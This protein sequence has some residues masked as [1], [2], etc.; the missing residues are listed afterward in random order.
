MA[1]VV[2]VYEIP[3]GL[4]GGLSVQD[5]SGGNY[6]RVLQVEF[7]GIN[8]FVWAALEAVGDSESVPVYGEPHPEDL[9]SWCY[10]KR[11]E[12]VPDDPTTW[13]VTCRYARSPVDPN[14]PN[15]PQPPSQNGGGEPPAPIPSQK[16]TWGTWTRQ[17]AWDD[18]RNGVAITNSA[19]DPFDPPI[20]TDEHLIE[21]TV[22]RSQSTFSTFWK[23]ECEG[24]V[25]DAMFPGFGDFG[26]PKRTLKVVEITGELV[27]ATDKTPRYWT[28]TIRIQHDPNGWQARPL[29]RGYR[30]KVGANRVTILKDG[31]RPAHPPL[32]DGAGAALADGAAPVFLDGNGGRKGPFIV[33]WEIDFKQLALDIPED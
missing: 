15:S 3:D 22:V 19:D 4:T 27:P 33:H 1:N 20:T 9:T 12:P 5:A 10:D 24:A 16:V 18:D 30:K 7:D 32:L 26:A 2:D 23:K 14:A 13:R 11:A 6:T 28:V 31:L 25:N 17:K 8:R 21:L 29:D